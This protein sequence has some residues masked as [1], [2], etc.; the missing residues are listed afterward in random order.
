MFSLSESSLRNIDGV[1]GDLLK[2]ANLAITITTVDFGYGKDAGLRT[3]ERQNK[4]YRDGSSHKDGYKKTSRHQ[5]GMAIDFYAYSDGEARWN[6][7]LLAMVAAAHLQAASI[8]GIKV[9]WGGLWVSESGGVYGWDMPHI[10]K[11]EE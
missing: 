9:E 3:A 11:V 8:L 10:Q 1:D 4:L 6:H 2:I 5:D 7:E